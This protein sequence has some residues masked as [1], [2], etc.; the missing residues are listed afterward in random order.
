[1]ANAHNLAVKTIAQKRAYTLIEKI[2]GKTGKAADKFFEDLLWIVD[3]TVV[4]ASTPV[5]LRIYIEI[6]WNTMQRVRQGAKREPLSAL[7]LPDSVTE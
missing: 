1:M 6:I 7:V 4:E 3:L 5:Q 2:T